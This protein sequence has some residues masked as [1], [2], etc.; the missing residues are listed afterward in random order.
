M[1]CPS[2]ELV[3][4]VAQT[5]KT[6]QL[7]IEH[8]HEKLELPS[9]TESAGVYFNYLP[10]SVVICGS[11][12]EFQGQSSVDIPRFS[13]FELYRRAIHMPEIITFDELHERAVAIVEAG[14]AVRNK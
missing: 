1:W 9:N 10:R 14:F 11:L 5:Q 4:A 12:S 7:A 13:S 6:V 3:G 2:D 8:L